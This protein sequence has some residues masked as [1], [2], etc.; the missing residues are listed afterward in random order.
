MLSAPVSY[1]PMNGQLSY[2]NASDKL[3]LLQQGRSS[4]E[5]GKGANSPF[6]EPVWGCADSRSKNP[7]EEVADDEGE[8]SSVSG[9][10]GSWRMHG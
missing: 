8:T 5:G 6:N 9:R 7:L 10:L 3:V 4:E 2:M 1:G